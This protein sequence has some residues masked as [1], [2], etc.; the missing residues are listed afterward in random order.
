[1]TAVG[2]SFAVALSTNQCS[3]KS[4]ILLAALF[5]F[6][7][8]SFWFLHLFV[9]PVKVGLFAMAQFCLFLEVYVQ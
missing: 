2:V 6:F 4:S 1:M 5:R 8:F 9:P 3:C 7:F